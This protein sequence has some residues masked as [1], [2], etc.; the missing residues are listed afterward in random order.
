[1][2]DSTKVKIYVFE[3]TVVIFLMLALN[4]WTRIVT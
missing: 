3:A 1:M 4:I 2:K